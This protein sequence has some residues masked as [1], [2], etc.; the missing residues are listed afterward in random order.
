MTPDIW[1]VNGKHKGH[2][3]GEGWIVLVL[4][5]TSIGALFMAGLLLVL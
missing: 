2:I 5:S 4:G 3:P 1:D